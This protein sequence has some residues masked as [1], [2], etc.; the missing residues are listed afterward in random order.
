MIR[1]TWDLS[2]PCPF[3]RMDDARFG[4]RTSTEAK[5]LGDAWLGNQLTYLY[6]PA[7]VGKTSLLLPGGRRQRGATLRRLAPRSACCRSAA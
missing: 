3:G 6:G 2:P 5:R 7:G 1:F 4:G